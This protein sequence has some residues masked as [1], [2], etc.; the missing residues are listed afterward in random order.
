MKI[1]NKIY[2]F[3]LLT[4][5]VLFFSN[6]I[7]CQ[8]I[9]KCSINSKEIST[10]VV[11]KNGVAYNKL[12]VNQTIPETCLGKPDLPY[13]IYKFYIPLSQKAI[14]VNFK[15][16]KQENIKLE[17]DLLPCQRPLLTS[18][19]KID[20]SFIFPEKSIYERN[21][22]FPQVQAKISNVEYFDG[23][24]EIITVEVYPIRYNPKLRKLF[25]DT[26]YDISIET[27]S[28]ISGEKNRRPKKRL[29][30]VVD[31]LCS[32]VTNKNDVLADSEKIN[33][34]TNN[35]ASKSP[36]RVSS[37]VNSL[38]PYY[39]YVI[40]TDASLVG[41]FDDFV[42]WK[43]RKGVNIGIVTT[44]DIYSNYA[45]D[46]ISVP[47][48]NDNPGKVRQ[49]LKDA[50]FNGGTIWALIAGDNNTNIPIRYSYTVFQ[51]NKTMPTD[52]Y[53]SD[54]H[55][56][57]NNNDPLSMPDIYVGR[58]ICSNSVDIQNWSKKVLLYEQNPGNGD[59]GYLLKS[60]SIQADQL[61]D[62]NEANNVALYF[63][64]ITPTI[65]GEN[66]TSSSIYDTNGYSN[67][68]LGVTKGADVINEMNNHYGMFGWFCHGG[69]GGGWYQCNPGGSNIATMTGGTNNDT[70]PSWALCAEDAV[71]YCAG[72][73][74]AEN[75]NGL[76]NLSN[77]N[78]PSLLYSVS[79]DVTPFNHT[80]NYN[81]NGSMNCGEA[82]TILPQTG[83]IAFLGNTSY[84]WVYSSSQMYKKFATLVNY[85]DFHSHLGVSECLSRYQYG[86]LDI[87]YS[88]NLIGCPETQMWTNLPQKFESASITKTGSTVT[89]NTGGITD[90][91]ICLMSANDNGASYY[92]VDPTSSE[93][94]FDN[95]PEGYYVTISKYNYIPYMYSSDY[96]I[97]NE[98]L[99]GTQIINATNVT[100]GSNITTSK[101]SG[102]VIIQSGANITI[103]AD[104]NT[105]INDTFEVE[106]GG[107][108]EIK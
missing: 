7:Q 96:Y 18:N 34:S 106:L 29:D 42:K 5:T 61:Q 31:I 75:G 92:S 85:N 19:N 4:F 15:S 78:Y 2:L 12:F 43:K 33:V 50:H 60:F 93:T 56:N 17:N 3:Y 52:S 76:D 6:T 26:E 70:Y 51:D 90:C 87:S 77:E 10:I 94:V 68:I 71:D 45:G 57:W 40:I 41:G 48:I 73:R 47:A 1:Y 79:C 14:G 88:H 63:P 22:I 24:L 62:Y 83:G 108:L 59:Y 30:H 49:Y 11:T 105:I 103:D 38:L 99:I 23:N 28:I 65:W 74:I 97:Q 89:V 9:K 95:V 54:L 81:N 84:G 104:E 37:N 55:G 20:T 107:A 91:K 64:S 58:L 32:T 86:M 69:T 21:S 46:N 13:Y 44:N 25:V 102:P 16:T 80:K 39:E 82:F 27:A 100:A 67:S 36:A 35:D 101:P 53:F 72:N 98:T 8:I 66:P